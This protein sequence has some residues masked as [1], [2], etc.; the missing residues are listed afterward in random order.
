[1]KTCQNCGEEFPTSIFVEGKRKGLYN[2]KY[3]LKCVP[4]GSRLSPIKKVKTEEQIIK[5]R[6]QNV[7][8]VQRH[9]IAV[10][11]K[12]VVYKGGKCTI[13]GYNNYYGALEFHH[14]DPNEKDFSI[15]HDGHCRSWEKV[16]V[17]LD[18]C[19]CVCAN[20]HREI[21]AGMID[22]KKYI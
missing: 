5:E 21:H 6:K 11:E 10:K 3:C 4:Y 9:R 22:L 17:E 2:R 15:S 13:C 18:K 7:D 20:C 12:A 14:L 16:K 1:M 19:I 8:G